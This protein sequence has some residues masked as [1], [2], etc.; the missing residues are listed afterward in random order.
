MDVSKSYEYTNYCYSISLDN[1]VKVLIQKW[2]NYYVAVPP[3]YAGDIEKI[4]AK[5]YPEAVKKYIQLH[6]LKEN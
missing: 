6:N 5:T 4:Y 2:G 1:G 3:K